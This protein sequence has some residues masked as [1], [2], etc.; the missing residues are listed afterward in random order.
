MRGRRDDVKKGFESAEP[1]GAVPGARG[2]HSGGCRRHIAAAADMRGRGSQR[3]SENAPRLKI[4]RFSGEGAGGGSRTLMP[5]WGTPDF[6]S[7]A[8]DQFRHPGLLRAY[9]VPG[10]RELTGN[11]SGPLPRNASRNVENAFSSNRGQ[12]AI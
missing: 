11:R 2:F 3:L 6:K 1:L 10:L 5:P 7:G 8:Y 4:G 12:T 9:Y